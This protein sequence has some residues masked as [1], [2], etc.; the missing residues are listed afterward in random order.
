[1]GLVDLVFSEIEKHW[2]MTKKDEN[3]NFSRDGKDWRKK[4]KKVKYTKR[5]T[6]GNKGPPS[7]HREYMKKAL[8]FDILHS[9][10]T[11]KAT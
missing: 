1:M 2:N 10:K 7:D 3:C 6:H 4:Q 11:W 5:L 8:S 9:L